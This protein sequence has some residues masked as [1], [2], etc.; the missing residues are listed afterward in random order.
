MDPY[1]SLEGEID[2]RR[3]IRA[4]YQRLLALAQT[5]TAPRLQAETPYRFGNRLS[6]HPDFDEGPMQTITDAYQEARYGDESPSQQT[7]A[8]VQRAWQQIES[9]L[10]S[11]ESTDES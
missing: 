11:D 9:G 8:Q 3:L 10:L 1:L 7:A 4:I 5:R 2:T 6:D